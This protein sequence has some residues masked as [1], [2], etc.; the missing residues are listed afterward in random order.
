MGA[1]FQ[2]AHMKLVQIIERNDAARVVVAELGERGIFQFRD[3]NSGTN[4]FKRSFSDDVRRCDDMQRRLVKMKHA[5]DLARVR[6]PV[7][8]EE[9]LRVPLAEL[10]TSIVQ[11]ESELKELTTQ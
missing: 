7:R 8:H 6:V 10:D 3:M 11:Y 2:S 1:L 9:G 5:L 4:F